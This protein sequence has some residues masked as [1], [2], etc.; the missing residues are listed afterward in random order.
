MLRHM[1]L[2]M[3]R[4]ARRTPPAGDPE[5]GHGRRQARGAGPRIVP[6]HH[7]RGG[8]SAPDV[9][10]VHDV[11]AKLPSRVIGGLMGLPEHDRPQLPHLG[12]DARR[13]G[14]RCHGRRN[15]TGSRSWSWRCTPSS[16]PPIGVRR[17]ARRPSRM[18]CAERLRRQP[19]TDVDFATF[20]CQLVAAGND[21]TKTLMS[22]GV[23]ARLNI[24]G[25]SQTC[26]PIGR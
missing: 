16:S 23:V 2:A 25:S 17:A 18:S 19:M 1:L 3:I 9:E 10:F 15:S 24:P 7:R 5:L 14:P 11:S 4:R 8:E 6:R 22:S 20:F 21:T 13:A 26:A 12:T